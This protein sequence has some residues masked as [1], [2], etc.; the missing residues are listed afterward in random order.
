MAVARLFSL[1]H[2][3]SFSDPLKL[4]EE[5]GF[6]LEFC[7]FITEK[8]D[9]RGNEKLMEGYTAKRDRGQMRR[10]SFIWRSVLVCSVETAEAAG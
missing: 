9:L 2:S 10:N 8:M 6:T 7:S 1:F 3:F 5:G 4:G